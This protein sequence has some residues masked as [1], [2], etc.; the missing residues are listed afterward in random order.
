MDRQCLKTAENT[1]FT[2]E[3][4]TR[5]NVNNTIGIVIVD[6]TRVNFMA[7]IRSYLTVRSRGV[8]QIITK[9]GPD[10]LYTAIF[11]SSICA[12]SFYGENLVTG[13]V[14]AIGTNIYRTPRPIK[15]RGRNKE[16]K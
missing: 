12:G 6:T 15:W 9:S 1:A 16:G 11:R 3:S 10:V 4:A 8:N 2:I 7:G 14:T 5:V 13:F